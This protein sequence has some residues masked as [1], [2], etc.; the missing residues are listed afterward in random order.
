MSF[1]AS[2]PESG[3]HPGIIWRIPEESPDCIEFFNEFSF[4][5]DSHILV[6]GTEHDGIPP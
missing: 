1:P 3:N 2:F 6:N 4:Q 5:I